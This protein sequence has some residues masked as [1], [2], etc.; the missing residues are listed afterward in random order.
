[1]VSTVEPPGPSFAR[2]A[3]VRVG[4]S[5]LGAVIAGFLASLLETIWIRGATA[6]PPGFFRTWLAASG[7]IVPVALVVGIG[8][9]CASLFMHPLEPPSLGRLQKYVARATSQRRGELLIGFPLAALAVVVF[10]VLSARLSLVV[11]ASEASAKASGAALGIVS[12]LL[13]LGLCVAVVGL[14]RALGPRFAAVE[15]SPIVT[16]AAG[17]SAALVLIG[18]FVATG[19]TSGSGGTLAMFGVLKR[20][21]LDLRAPALLAVI[22]LG[23]YLLPALLARLPLLVLTALPLL[24]LLVSFQASSSTLN[25]R[26]ISLSMERGAPLSK[27]VLGALRKSSDRDRDG[28]SARFGGG[29]CDDG[30]ADVNPGADDVPGNGLDEDCSGRDAERVALSA[31]PAASGKAAQQTALAALPKELNLVLITIDTLRYDLGFTGNPRPVS[32]NLDQLAKQSVV[33]ENAYALASYTSKSLAPMLIGKY[34]SETHRGWSHFNRF[35]KIGPFPAGAAAEGGHPH[36]QR[37]GLLVLLPGRGRLRAR[38]RRDRFV[39]SA[40]SHP[41]GGRP[42]GDRGQGERCRDR[43]ALEA[44][45]RRPAVLPLGALCR[46]PH[47]IRRARR[48]RFRL[49]QSGPVRQRSRVRRSSHRQ[50]ARFSEEE[51]ISPRTA[52]VVTSD[53]GEAFGEHGMIRHGFELWE[54]LVRVPLIVQIPGILPQRIAA[55]R[56]Q[57]DLVP[58]VLELLRQPLP[59]G[60]DSDF[61]SGQSLLAEIVSPGGSPQKKIVFV[62]MAAGPNNAER[63]AF[64]ENDLKLV[65]SGGRALSLFDLAKDPAEKTDLLDDQ[66]LSDPVI[67]RFKAFRRELRTVNVKPVPK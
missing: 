42:H 36:A 35:E 21:E 16:L 40:Q 54:E 4:A 47:R 67:S 56:S 28:F 55:R 13:A 2:K 6:E 59:S 57:I 45:E 49:D 19:T 20:P 50:A 51:R 10:L 63:Q 9:A 18:V 12:S 22:A 29:D 66:A 15:L 62:D 5:A 53:H 41:D 34:G 14:A 58:T 64:I 52:V 23:A 11:L 8:V 65:A 26:R 24:P 7:L 43:S 60:E 61:V 37:P 38:L 1:M 30:R 39:G 44:R 17:M 31:T 3:L 33:F 48:V 25:E 27:I 32:K 46:P